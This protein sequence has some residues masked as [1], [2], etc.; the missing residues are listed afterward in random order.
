MGFLS[1]ANLRAITNIIS[2]ALYA[3]IAPRIPEINS[4]SNCTFDISSYHTSNSTLGWK[5]TRVLLLLKIAF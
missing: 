1:S 2:T 5:I 3:S 4:Y